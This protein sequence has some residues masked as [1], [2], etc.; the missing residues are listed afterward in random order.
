MLGV[1]CPSEINK[2][3]YLKKKQNQKQNNTF[4]KYQPQNI[5]QGIPIAAQQ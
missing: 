5:E 1:W 2:N 4:K 3:G